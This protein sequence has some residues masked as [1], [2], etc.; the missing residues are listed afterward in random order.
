LDASTLATNH[1]SA[2]APETISNLILTT[3]VPVSLPYQGDVADFEV[4]VKSNSTLRKRKTRV[5]KTANI[6]SDYS[7][8]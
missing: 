1:S 6:T 5:S 8:E 7:E 3:V 2:D 4:E